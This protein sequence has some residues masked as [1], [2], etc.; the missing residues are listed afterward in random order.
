LLDKLL[1]HHQQQQVA[2]PLIAGLAD[3]AEVIE[4]AETEGEAD[5][6]GLP[7]PPNGRY[8]YRRLDDR[9]AATR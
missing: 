1:A 4:E 2:G 5:G 3:M 9:L 6:A 7:Q 8:N